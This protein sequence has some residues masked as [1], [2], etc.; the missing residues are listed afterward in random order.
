M[1]YYR[2][3]LDAPMWFTDIFGESANLWI[4]PS[5]PK[6][7]FKKGRTKYQ[8]TDL[9]CLNESAVDTFM[10]ILRQAC[11]T[12]DL[13]SVTFKSTDVERNRIDLIA[14]IVS[15]I[16]CKRKNGN[17]DSLFT[18][19]VYGTDIKETENGGTLITF[20]LAKEHAKIVYEYAQKQNGTVDY[21]DLIVAFIEENT[22]RLRKVSNEKIKEEKQ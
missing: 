21:Y 3:K 14:D 1:K 9:R 13:E 6:I 20:N 11:N 16:E 10:E 19:L 22:K 12:P 8:V 5:L 15:S 17:G 7:E 4:R 18:F 2:Q